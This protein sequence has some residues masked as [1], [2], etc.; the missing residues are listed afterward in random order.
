MVENA[1]LRQQ[2]IVLER[3]V[4][5]PKLSWRDRA[6]LVVLSSRVVTW[7]QTLLIV[8]PETVLRW[9]RDLFRWVWRRKSQPKPT[10]GRPRLPCEQ[11]T[12]IRRIAKENLSWG[13]ERIR[14]ELLKLGL[15]VAKSTIQRYLKGRRAAGPGSQTWRTFLR[16]HA[17]A[18]WACDFLQT[19][20]VWFRAIFVFVIIE[21]ASRRVVH[22][23]ITRHPGEAWVVQQLREATPFGQGPRHLIR[24][25]DNK[26]GSQFDTVAAGAGSRCS[27]RQLL[28]LGR[29]RC[30]KGSWAVYVG[31]VWIT[32]SS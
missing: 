18:I 20:D 32:C 22:V 11:V 7:K 21:L 29:T 13:T 4:K 2:L 6:I 17:S 14:G 9:D 16:N 27:T 30:A 28:P 31:N 3:Q 26:Y 5:R 25:N 24:D 23:G 12:L 19:R 10:I 8:K 1:L 15:P